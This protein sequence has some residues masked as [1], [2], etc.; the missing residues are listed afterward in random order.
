[1]EKIKGFQNGN[2]NKNLRV[3][4]QKEIAIREL[5]LMH[6]AIESGDY[7]KAIHHKIIANVAIDE[8]VGASKM[9]EE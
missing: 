6:R 5:D 9:V 1:M 2:G 8:M 4:H 7:K 3:K